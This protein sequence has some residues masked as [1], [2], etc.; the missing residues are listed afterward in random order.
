M[1]AID[2][3]VLNRRSPLYVW[4]L[5]HHSRFAR[6]LAKADKHFRWA[7]ITAAIAAE[8]LT[9]SQGKPPSKATVIAT[10]GR[11]SRAVAA[12]K[13]ETWGHRGR[14]KPP[15]EGIVRTLGVAPSGQPQA[16]AIFSEGGQRE[17]PKRQ[18]KLSTA[19]RDYLKNDKTDTK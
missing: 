15:A 17:T 6:S 13:P 7:D 14:A 18:F 9:D 4:M 8:G 3:A 2:R 11:V 5:T 16:G 10:W 19:K 1:A 12:R